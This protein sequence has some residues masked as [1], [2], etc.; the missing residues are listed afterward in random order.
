MTLVGDAVSRS[1]FILRKLVG[2]SRADR[3]ADLIAHLRRATV[4]QILLLGDSLVEASCAGTG[5]PRVARGSYSGSRIADVLAAVSRVKGAHLWSKVAGAV[6]SIGLNDAQTSEGDDLEFRRL[7]FRS[8]LD[9]LSRSFGE[10]PL[11][12]L[13]ITDIASAGQWV[14]R[15]N[16]RLIA[17]ENDEIAALPTA[18]I[19][20][21]ATLFRSAV[22]EAGLVYDAAFRDGVHFS[23]VGYRYW[24]PLVE[25]AINMV[26]STNI[27][28]APDQANRAMFSA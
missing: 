19:H 26:S 13:T 18:K 1:R 22:L 3:E 11:V 8:A 25:Q 10:K 4:P 2:T 28:K 24:D 15:F 20:D 7:Y 23:P 21:V 27:E 5:N 17:M 12:M 9:A 14:S 6:V 16:R